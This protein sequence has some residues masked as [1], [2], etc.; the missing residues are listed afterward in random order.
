MSLFILND[1]QKTSK[2]PQTVGL[3][4]P[5]PPHSKFVI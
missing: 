3:K 1:I 2:L 4:Y 5:K